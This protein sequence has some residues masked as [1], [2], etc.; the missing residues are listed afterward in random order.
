MDESRPHQSEFLKTLIEKSHRKNGSALRN[1]YASMNKKKR[2]DSQTK[3][4]DKKKPAKKFIVLR[5]STEPKEE[6]K[7]R[8]SGKAEKKKKSQ[9]N[10]RLKEKSPQEVKYSFPLSTKTKDVKEGINL[11]YYFSGQ[12]MK[13]RPQRHSTIK[14]P[15]SLHSVNFTENFFDPRQPKAKRLKTKLNTSN[16]RQNGSHLKNFSHNKLNKS[17]QKV[18]FSKNERGL[19]TPSNLQFT[20]THRTSSIE[21]SKKKQ[22]YLLSSFSRNKSGKKPAQ[23]SHKTELYLEGRPSK[24][25]PNYVSVNYSCKPTDHLYLGERKA[26]AKSTLTPLG[27]ADKKYELKLFSESKGL[28]SGEKPSKSTLREKP[29]KGWKGERERRE[30][31]GEAQDTTAK[32]QK[33]K[34][35]LT[36][37]TSENNALHTVNHNLK[38]PKKEPNSIFEEC[39]A[40][41]KENFEEKKRKK[42]IGEYLKILESKCG[43]FEKGLSGDAKEVREKVAICFKNW[44]SNSLAEFFDFKSSKSLYKIK[45]KVIRTKSEEGVLEKCIWRGNF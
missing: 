1:I 36:I 43:S 30:G 6:K 42:K 15:K 28:R 45:V 33:K 18:S 8:S 5:E 9:R 40:T 25:P 16:D 29:E 34:A 20:K 17:S 39:L 41:Q 22:H 10:I 14:N 35:N 27:R 12:F 4:S 2:R 38:G 32:N 37:N 31:L 11:G 23:F 26:E 21:N 7:E 44:K 24:K 13:G 19:L 3:K